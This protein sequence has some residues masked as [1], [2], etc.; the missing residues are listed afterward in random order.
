MLYFEYQNTNPDNQMDNPYTKSS[1]V[2]MLEHNAV[3]WL[4]K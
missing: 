4:K 2:N 3:R 1:Y